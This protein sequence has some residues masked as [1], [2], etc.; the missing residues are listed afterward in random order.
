MKKIAKSKRSHTGLKI[1]FFFFLIHSHDFNLACKQQ[2][3]QAQK[4]NVAGSEA[5]RD[6]PPGD[7]PPRL[8]PAAWRKVC[9]AP[10][11]VSWAWGIPRGDLDKTGWG[12]SRVTFCTGWWSLLGMWDQRPRLDQKG[13][14]SCSS[15]AN[16]FYILCADIGHGPPQ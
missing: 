1:D 13:D 9:P 11:L 3:L 10:R 12:V 6:A 14:K 7:V 4:G 8:T 15:H 5:G 16:L 2:A